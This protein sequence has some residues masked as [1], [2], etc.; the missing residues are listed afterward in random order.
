LTL[1]QNLVNDAPVPISNATGTSIQPF[2]K[3]FPDDFKLWP[4]DTLYESFNDS[5]SEA[6]WALL[7]QTFNQNSVVFEHEVN[8]SSLESYFFYFF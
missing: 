4:E 7:A 5:N 3:N 6:P 2:L 8:T 1:R